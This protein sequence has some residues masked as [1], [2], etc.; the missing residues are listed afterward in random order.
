M[1]LR[2]LR[3]FEDKNVLMYIFDITSFLRLFEPLT[4]YSGFC[5]CYVDHF[6]YL[7]AK[8]KLLVNKLSLVTRTEIISE[9]HLDIEL[10]P[11]PHPEGHCH[12]PTA[13]IA[14]DHPSVAVSAST[15]RCHARASSNHQRRHLLTS[16]RGREG[17]RRSR[18]SQELGGLLTGL[19]AERRRNPGWPLA[20]V[21]TRKG[22]WAARSSL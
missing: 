20:S 10:P 14:Q 16:S 22:G 19:I 2:F 7:K 1:A 4:T 21:H 6:S 13:V 5:L 17:Q 12:L 9:L 11:P 3:Q 8:A 15:G 18:A